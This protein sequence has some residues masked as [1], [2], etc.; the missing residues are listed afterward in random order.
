[1]SKSKI[2]AVLGVVLLLGVIVSLRSTKASH[3]DILLTVKQSPFLETLDTHAEVDALFYDELRA[4]AGRYT[5]QLIYLH[6]EGA[7]VNEGDLVAEFDTADLFQHIDEMAEELALHRQV[8]S[9][10]E[11]NLEA[12]L[13]TQEVI[14]DRVTEELRI[15]EISKIRMMH[16]SEKRR[17][18]AQ[19]KFNNS[20][21]TVEAAEKKLKQIQMRGKRSLS[22]MD[23]RRKV[24]ERRIA[25][26]EK[27]A[28]NY[29]LYAEQNS[30]VVYPVIA[31]SGE[32]KKVQEG[33]AL[34]QNIEFCRLPQF[35][36]KV[37]RVNLE[38]Q[39]VN[40]IAEQGPVTFTPLSYPE[41]TFAGQILSISTLAKEGVYRSHKKFFEVIIEID[42]TDAEAFN[43]LK[44]G[45]VCNLQFFIRD[46]GS[47]IAVPKD[48]VST[49]VAGVPSIRV[50]D[51]EEHDRV[52][53]LPDA[54]ETLDYYLLDDESMNELT[55]VLVPSDVL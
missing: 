50:R 49:S 53:E 39:W 47:V 11:I 12:E 35:S 46:W 13:F 30:M 40:K 51:V 2:I 6:P 34:N 21:R 8:R 10:R 54:A 23:R 38:E 44:P 9:D 19:S 45:M 14:I 52:I 20:Q 33:D 18:I 16:E 36:S 5:K 43:L 29:R 27:E 1:M 22:N 37:I 4:P 3:E 41:E 31:L 48:Y 17:S 7:E 25:N 55:L 26:I 24:L 42:N 28:A 15:A 32:W